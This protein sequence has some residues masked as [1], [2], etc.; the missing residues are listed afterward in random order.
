MEAGHGLWARG[1]WRAL[2]PGGTEQ[3]GVVSLGCASLE[4]LTLEAEAWWG[5]WAPNG[6]TGNST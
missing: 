1:R 6:P 3:G 4:C 2:G 5:S